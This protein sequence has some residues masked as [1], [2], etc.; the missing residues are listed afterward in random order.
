[1]T[2]KSAK[3][4]EFRLTDWQLFTNNGNFNNPIPPS[5]RLKRRYPYFIDRIDANSIRTRCKTARSRSKFVL[6]QI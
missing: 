4:R 5:R 6:I 2:S 3:S 1:M